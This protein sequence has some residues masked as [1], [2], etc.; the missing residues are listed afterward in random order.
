MRVLSQYPE[1]V[2]NLWKII[3]F[4]VLYCATFVITGPFFDEYKRKH[5]GQLIA[6]S[7]VL[8]AVVLMLACFVPTERE[9][10]HI[11]YDVIFDESTSQ[12]EIMEQYDVVENRGDLYI[13]RDLESE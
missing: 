3:I 4:V 9:S 2:S 10:G 13:I 12:E 5:I 1:M 8:L 11:L 7:F 6:V